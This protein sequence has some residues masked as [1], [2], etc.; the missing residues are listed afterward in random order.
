MGVCL[1]LCRLYKRDDRQFPFWPKFMLALFVLFC[2]KWGVCKWT[3]ERK[4]RASYVAV[5]EG[6]KPTEFPISTLSLHSLHLLEISWNLHPHPLPPSNS[7]NITLNDAAHSLSYW[8]W[9]KYIKANFLPHTQTC[10]DAAQLFTPI[11]IDRVLIWRVHPT[12]S[13]FLSFW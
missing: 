5:R 13:N 3:E 9:W 8:D 12:Y 4:S 6:W 10:F 11:K 2:V 1:N 7:S